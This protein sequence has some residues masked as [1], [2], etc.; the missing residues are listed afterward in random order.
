MSW[1][2]EVLRKLLDATVGLRA[3]AQEVTGEAL[4]AKMRSA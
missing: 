1:H 2:A 3:A 4:V